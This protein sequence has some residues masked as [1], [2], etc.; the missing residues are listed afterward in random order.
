[1]SHIYRPDVET[2]NGLLR[3]RER[4]RLQSLISTKKDNAIDVIKNFTSVELKKKHPRHVT[5]GVAMLSYMDCV[6]P[7]S[8]EWLVASGHAHVWAQVRMVAYHNKVFDPHRWDI[9]DMYARSL[10][11]GVLCGFD[12]TSPL[13]TDDIILQTNYL[14]DVYE[15]DVELEGIKHE[16][17]AMNKLATME[18]KMFR[19][20][21]YLPVAH[22]KISGNED[23]ESD[24]HPEELYTHDASNEFAGAKELKMLFSGISST[25]EG[26]VLIR[27]FKAYV[28]KQYMEGNHPSPPVNTEDM[29]WL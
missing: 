14:M 24:D 1:M 12:V 17:L 22:E 11:Q 3:G 27:D 10:L 5:L 7:Y 21:R 29:T 15:F 18:L 20:C 25:A 19:E 8:R 6:F 2:P 4:S 26:G 23:D 9:P 13:V 28:T 16:R